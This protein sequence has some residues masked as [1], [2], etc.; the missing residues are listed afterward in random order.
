MI[1]LILTHPGC[2]GG[3]A[4]VAV[5]RLKK[6]KLNARLEG[7]DIIS[8]TDPSQSD[9]AIETLKKIGF[10]VSPVGGR[11][12]GRPAAGPEAE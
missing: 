2:P 8:V 7:E 1:K 10:R 6:A 12:P 9:L 3:A 4:A 11:K 5:E